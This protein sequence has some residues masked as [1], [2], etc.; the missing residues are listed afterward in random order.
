MRLAVTKR[1]ASSLFAL[2]LVAAACGAQTGATS[3]DLGGGT[4]FVPAI[5]DAVDD[6]GMMP[7]LAL[8]DGAPVVLYF[9]F[10]AEL[11]PGEIPVTRSVYAPT[12]PSIL[13]ASERDGIFTRGAVVVPKA[14]PN[15][16]T[17][18]FGPAVDASVGSITPDSVNGT[19]IAVDDQGGIHA[20]WVSDTGL[21]YGTG[22]GSTQ[23]S[24]E[25]VVKPAAKLKQAGPLGPPAIAVDADGTPWIAFGDDTGG[26]QAIRVATSSGDRWQI[27][28]V[29]AF[30]ACGGCPEPRRVG[31]GVADEGPVI[32]YSDPARDTPVAATLQGRTW[33]T[34]DIENGGGGA[35]L[36]LTVDGDGAPH[37]AYYTA[38]GAVHEATLR[39]G[40]WSSTTV[41]EAGSA[42]D[43]AL[44]TTGV[45]VDGEGTSY[46][47]YYDGA[48]DSVVLASDQDG[49]FSAIDTPGTRG[50]G[51]PAVAAEGSDVFVA[52]FDHVN[53]NLDLGILGKAAGEL[54]LANPSPT[55]STSA[56]APAASPT[57]AGG[58]APC[59][60]TG[61]EADLAAPSGAATAGF[62]T[63]C[64]SIDAGKA[65]KVTLDNQDP[66]VPHN[67]ALFEDSAFTKQIAAT[68]LTPGPATEETEVP[69][70]K[71][72]TFF[73]HCDAHPATMTGQ[74]YVA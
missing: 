4:E 52:W 24:I 31:I 35:G 23:F 6:V 64:L 46:V 61:N 8:A 66:G 55:P 59:K 13:L 43:A 63:Q 71:Q 68:E 20:A 30:G 41:G 73:Y 70:L 72:G 28:D 60:S 36:S 67:W 50:A 32:A 54:A 34:Q 53:Q 62:S 33:Q 29:A 39:S 38:D 1:L 48:T 25:R 69:A 27:S 65:A 7:S 42:D 40:A 58:E 11:A 9:G 12:V 57:Q 51:M 2:A 5:A 16:V 74:L 44:Q 45:A 26:Q 49:S 15:L 56:A 14:P 19:T 22:G 37:V 18:P 10:P 47:A 17:I 3:V 21:W